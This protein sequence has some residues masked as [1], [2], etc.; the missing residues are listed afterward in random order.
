MD[1]SKF[2]KEPGT[3]SEAFFRSLVLK[4]KFVTVYLFQYWKS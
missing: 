1:R 3:T 4:L 2:A